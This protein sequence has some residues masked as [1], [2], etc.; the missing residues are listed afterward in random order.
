MR[1][2]RVGDHE[3]MSSQNSLTDE[4]KDGV[5][6]FSLCT[7]SIGNHNTATKHI[8]SCALLHS[9]IPKFRDKSSIPLHKLL[10]PSQ[11][12]FPAHGIVSKQ[13]PPL[14]FYVAYSHTRN[15]HYQLCLGPRPVV[16]ICNKSISHPTR[17]KIILYLFDVC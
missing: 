11:S 12:E 17:A 10:I 6:I 2:E 4:I 8:S 16:A 9:E 5:S 14:R 7:W 15:R 3:T 1:R 13:I